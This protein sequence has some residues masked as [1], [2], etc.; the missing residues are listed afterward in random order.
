MLKELLDK[1]K[2]LQEKNSLVFSLKVRTGATKTVIKDVMDDGV[3]KMDVAEIPEKGR[4]NQEII[5][6]FK[7]FFC[8][9]SADIKISS[10]A[11]DK[12]KI[13]KIK[14]Q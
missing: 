13:I 8:V 12:F 11:K 1:K 6:F 5:K 7:N 3:V 9:E 14:K 2:I 4:A 10:G